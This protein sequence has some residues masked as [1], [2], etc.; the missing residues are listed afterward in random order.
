MNDENLVRG[1]V[2]IAI[3]LTFGLSALRYPLG[4]FSRAGPG[5]FPLMVSSLL[6]LIG[7]ATVIKSRFDKRKPLYFNVRNISIILLSLCGFALISKYVNMIA[8]IVFMVFFSSFA[9]STYSIARNAK[10]AAGLVA[11]AFAFQ[12]LLG[13]NLPLY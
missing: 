11:I 2:L 10:V 13:L 4:D 7:V 9:A 8:G 12:K 1:L 5:L 3:A 6:L